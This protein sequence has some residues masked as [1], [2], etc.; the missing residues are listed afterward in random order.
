LDSRDDGGI[1]LDSGYDCGLSLDRRDDSGLSLD[2]RDDG[3]L[4]LD[5]G[6]D[7]G[8]SL[9][10]SGGHS[11]SLVNSRVQL[12]LYTAASS[13]R[14]DDPSHHWFQMR[15]WGQAGTEG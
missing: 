13:C 12:R 5:S 6:Y 3:G 14:S 2:S 10:S 8:L 1:S 4:S 9:D 11:H 15:L 7:G